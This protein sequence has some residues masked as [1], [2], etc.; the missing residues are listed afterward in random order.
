V[1]EYAT[2]KVCAKK[3]TRKSPVSSET[4]GGTLFNAFI[5]DLEKKM[6]EI[7]ERKGSCVARQYL[8]QNH[9]DDL[10]RILLLFGIGTQIDGGQ[11]LNFFFFFKYSSRLPRNILSLF[12]PTCWY[13]YTH[14]LPIAASTKISVPQKYF[15]LTASEMP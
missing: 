15:I 10:Q 14:D 11:A 8:A 2:A 1:S 13:C 4:L 12:D 6:L 7:L 5:T 3:N 9:D